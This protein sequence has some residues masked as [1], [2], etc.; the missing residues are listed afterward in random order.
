MKHYKSVEFLSIFRVSNPLAQTQR[1]PQKGKA[2]LLKTFWRRF[3]LHPW[4]IQVH[5]GCTIHPVDKHCARLLFY[6][7]IWMSILFTGNEWI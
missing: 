1:P 7:S 2:P 4:K 6:S 3:W 5:P